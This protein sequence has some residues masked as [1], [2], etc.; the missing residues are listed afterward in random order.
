MKDTPVTREMADCCDRKCQNIHA[1][2]WVVFFSYAQFNASSHN[3]DLVGLRK[4]DN[5]FTESLRVQTLNNI[6][7]ESA[8]IL[9][10]E[11][12]FGLVI[13]RLLYLEGEKKKNF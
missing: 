2:M 7:P 5:N 10:Y 12:S 13:H 1:Y 8:Q 6:F 11:A 3:V 9:R 4:T